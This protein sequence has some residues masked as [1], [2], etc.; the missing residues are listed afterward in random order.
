VCVFVCVCV[1]VCVCVYRVSVCVCMCVCGS[2][3]ERKQYRAFVR[4]YCE[5]S[6]CRHHDSRQL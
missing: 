2:V 5:S 1:C 4:S 3:E 6:G